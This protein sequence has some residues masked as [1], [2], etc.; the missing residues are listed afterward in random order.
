MNFISDYAQNDLTPYWQQ[1]F[2]GGSPYDDPAPYLERSP[3]FLADRI[4]VPVLLVHGAEDIRVTPAQSREMYT[5]LREKG[6]PVEL[7]IY[8]REEHG[9]SEPRHQIDFMKRQL[10]WF[11]RFLRPESA[12]PGARK[13]GAGF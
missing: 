9:I 1:E 3:V 2:I 4:R 8:P 10:E 7:V 11:D 6:A 13:G 12:T 5:A